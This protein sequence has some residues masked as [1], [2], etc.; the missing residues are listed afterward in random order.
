VKFKSTEI[1]ENNF[2]FT[3]IFDILESAILIKIMATKVK[4]D[5]IKKNPKY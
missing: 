2:H 1:L 3:I 5:D 4:T